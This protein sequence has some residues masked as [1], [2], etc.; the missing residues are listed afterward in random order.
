MEV[1]L[2]G[3]SP[4]TGHYLAIDEYCMLYCLRCLSD[5]VGFIFWSG[6]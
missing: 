2:V 3:S 4:I 5:V 1:L 6:S